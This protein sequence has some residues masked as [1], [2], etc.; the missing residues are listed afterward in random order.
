MKIL[1]IVCD[2]GNEL[3]HGEPVHGPLSDL[4]PTAGDDKASLVYTQLL[5]QHNLLSDPR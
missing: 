4:D 1:L 5:C 3:Y 2:D